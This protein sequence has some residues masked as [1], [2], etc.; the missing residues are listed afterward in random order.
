MI[1]PSGPMLVQTL[2]PAEGGSN[3]PGA[4]QKHKA[5]QHDF[6]EDGFAQHGISPSTNSALAMQ[7][8]GRCFMDE[9]AVEK[10]KPATGKPRLGKGL[11]RP[12]IC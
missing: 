12:K 6:V 1:P 4:Q 2:Y 11:A 10:Q 7:M 3:L 9:A 5:D 8:I